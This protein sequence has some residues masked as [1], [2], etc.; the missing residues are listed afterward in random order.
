PR[1]PARAGPTGVGQERR[2]RR[3]RRHVHLA[4]RGRAGARGR[5]ARDG[6]GEGARAGTG[7]LAR[8]PGGPLAHARSGRVRRVRA[9]AARHVIVRWGLAELSPALRELEIS[10]P[11]L[12]A[13][14]R[15]SELDLPAAGR[16]G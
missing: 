11:F 14:D 1:R 9:F 10:Q 6:A 3:V 8:P 2:R 7:D 4:L 13:S 15:W 12:I 5:D 16:W